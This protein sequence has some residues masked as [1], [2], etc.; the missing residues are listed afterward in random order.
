MGV[1]FDGVAEGV[2]FESAEFGFNIVCTDQL[3]G[4]FVVDAVVDQVGD[5]ADLDVV[6]FGKH[7]HRF[8]VHA[9]VAL[10]RERIVVHV[11]HF[12]R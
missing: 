9:C 12:F 11:S 5:G 3:N 4:F 7:F 6:F 10:P 1:A 2:Q 8:S